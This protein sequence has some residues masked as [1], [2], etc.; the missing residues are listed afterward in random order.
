LVFIPPRAN[1]LAER[2][3]QEGSRSVGFHAH[4]YLERRRLGRR[5]TSRGPGISSDWVSRSGTGAEAAAGDLEVRRRIHHEA[6]E[7]HEG[8]QGG[9]EFRHR[10]TEITE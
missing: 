1:R 4:R 5:K 6:H 10:A 9:E 3:E 2:H 7:G 8:R